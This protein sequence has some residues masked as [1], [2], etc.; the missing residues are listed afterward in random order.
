MNIFG[1][2]PPP[3]V[4]RC[5]TDCHL[6]GE[7]ARAPAISCWSHGDLAVVFLRCS[8]HT[9]LPMPEAWK[10]IFLSAARSTT[11]RPSNKKAGFG[12]PA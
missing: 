9:G 3:L 8:R 10:P 7:G 11:F 2:S 6:V 5:F 4:G 1:A 12:I